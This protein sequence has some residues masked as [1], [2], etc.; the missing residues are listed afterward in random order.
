MV[1]IGLCNVE[2][3]PNFLAVKAYCHHL[4]HPLKET[5]GRG[6]VNP[7][8]SG[9]Q[10][11]PSRV[12]NHYDLFWTTLQASVLGCGMPHVEKVAMR[13]FVNLKRIVSFLV[14]S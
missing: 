9:D 14:D 10:A 3:R 8:R 11:K 1:G 4:K 12:S 6:R 13:A 5:N 2:R 7:F